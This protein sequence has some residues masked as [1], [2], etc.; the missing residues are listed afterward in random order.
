M[1]GSPYKKRI[2]IQIHTEGRP[3][4][5]R[6]EDGHLQA[7]D[8]LPQEEIKPIVTFILERLTST[9]VRKQIS[10]AY[11]LCLWIFVTAAL[12]N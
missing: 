2:L 9:T 12:A 5:D 3:G 6:G 4:E 7:K 1:T 11:T 8:L 10:V